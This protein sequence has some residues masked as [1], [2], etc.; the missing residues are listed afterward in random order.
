MRSVVQRILFTV[1][2]VAFSHSLLHAQATLFL[3]EPYSLDGTFAGTGHSAVYLSRV[4]A[5]SPVRLRRCAPGELGA[6]ISR[7]H[8]IAGRDWI[9]IPLIPYL[10]AVE[11]PSDIPLVADPRLVAFLRHQYLPHLKQIANANSED[12]EPVG[13][14]YELVGSAYDRSLYGFQIATTPQEDDA[15]IRK[16]NSSPNREAYSLFRRNCADFSKQ[17]INFYYPR[18][19]HRS[20]IADLGVTTPKQ[21][22]KTLVHY[23]KHH[24][25]TEMTSFIIPQVPGTKRSRPVHGVLESVLFSKKYMALLF[26]LHPLAVGGVETAYL[27]KWHFDPSHNAMMFDPGHALEPPLSGE[28]QRAYQAKLDGLLE[29]NGDEKI[30]S[31]W[32]QLQA[33]AV[34]RV[35]DEGRPVLEIEK[36]GHTVQVGI[37][38]NEALRSGAPELLEQLMLFR[39]D[40]ELKAGHPARASER[41]VESDWSLLQNALADQPR[42]LAGKSSVNSSRSSAPSPRLAPGATDAWPALSATS[43][44]T[45][46]V[47]P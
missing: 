17:I 24:P 21:V 1:I 9:A 29:S 42:E 35:N 37:S 8:G 13:P 6:V 27:A 4:C 25:R 28:T 3:E 26:F 34:P 22:A 38:R 30:F 15:L 11:K 47:A 16:L 45:R 46:P 41:Q 20:V 7:Y 12:G 32:A 39:L 43:N 31:N 36:D 14:W 19:T 44:R 40:S 33:Q 23:S 2:V 10:Y 5:A 18:S